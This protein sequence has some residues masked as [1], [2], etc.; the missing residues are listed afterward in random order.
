MIH[1]FTQIAGQGRRNDGDSV[2]PAL[3]GSDLFSRYDPRAGRIKTL[4]HCAGI[5]GNLCKSVDH[6]L[7]IGSHTNL[8]PDRNLSDLRR[9]EFLNRLGFAVG[10]RIDRPV[11][12][13][14]RALDAGQLDLG[15]MGADVRCQGDRQSQEGRAGDAEQ[16]RERT[17][18]AHGILHW[19]VEKP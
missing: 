5:A 19:G 2:R 9:L 4:H 16:D 18:V 8:S 15:A 7:G 12:A 1:R 17:I 13:G 11:G 14:M 3:R 10:D 6:F